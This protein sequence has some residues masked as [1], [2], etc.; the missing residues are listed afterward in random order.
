MDTMKDQKL[1][2]L[3]EH[4]VATFSQ[5]LAG[6]KLNVRFNSRAETASFHF[7]SRT[8]TFPTYGGKIGG[9]ALV[10][11]ALHETG[12]ATDTDEETY[13]I[14]A[15]KYGGSLIN[16]L[17]DVRIEKIVKSKFANANK[18]L[19]NSYKELILEHNFFGTQDQTNPFDFSKMNFMSRIN[20]YYKVGPLGTPV[21]STIE[22]PIIDMINNME[23]MDDLEVIAKKIKSMIKK[24]R[25]IKMPKDAK[26]EGSAPAEPIEFDPSE[27][28]DDDDTPS[29]DFDSAE[30][31]E[32]DES[33]ENSDE[34]NLPLD[35]QDLDEMLEDLDPGELF[36]ESDED[37][38]SDEDDED[39]L[40]SEADGAAGEHA[41]TE[42]D[43]DED[44]LEND[45]TDGTE[46]DLDEDDLENDET[47]QASKDAITNMVS[48]KADVKFL[49]DNGHVLEATDEY[50]EPL[51]V[52]QTAKLKT[53]TEDTKS[54]VSTMVTEFNRKA[55]AITRSKKRRSDS[56]LIDVRKISQFNYNDKIFLKKVKQAAGKNH[57]VVL[58]IDMSGSM[59]WSEWGNDNRLAKVLKQTF[60]MTEFLKSINVPFSVIGWSGNYSPPLRHELE[61]TSD[62]EST[63]G[64]GNTMRILV[65]SKMSKELIRIRL[66]NMISRSYNLSSGG[67]PLIASIHGSIEYVEGFKR[68]NKLDV[69]NLLVLTDGDAGDSWNNFDIPV[70]DTTTGRK[71]SVKEIHKMVDWDPMNQYNNKAKQQSTLAFMAELLRTRVNANLVLINLTSKGDIV[72]I[73]KFVNSDEE[74]KTV[75]KNLREGHTVVMVTDK[76]PFSIVGIIN[77]KFSLGAADESDINL[78]MVAE[79]DIKKAFR[80]QLVNK[81]NSAFFAKI[82]A[83][84]I[85]VR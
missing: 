63:Y 47:D 79:K 26:V 73:S 43:L 35:F 18:F 32:D 15:R 9:D 65:S 11:L 22:L 30:S 20:T 70:V 12:H 46:L 76:R 61:A 84:R 54:I 85:A 13:K 27:F 21:W 69:V 50:S 49:L 51:G 31:D 58:L 77:N 17:E 60:V 4:V 82:V 3:S 8:I 64:S 74:H 45:E 62:L 52:E 68:A 75:T 66:T 83:D 42:L 29:H 34:D 5:F 19:I 41:G 67:T 37:S 78:D 2:E 55:N 14:F 40:T 38:E 53:L 6:E 7:D 81:R 33:D 80:T 56:G 10:G 36:P 24:P 57:G 71:Y 59:S 25:T 72:Q 48:D 16:I 44:D 39:D 28:E 1:N 23:T